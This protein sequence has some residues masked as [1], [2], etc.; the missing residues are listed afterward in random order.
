MAYLCGYQGSQAVNGLTGITAVLQSRSVTLPAGGDLS[1]TVALEV[2]VGKE[3]PLLMRYG[4]G[5]FRQSGKSDQQL[6][7]FYELVNGPELPGDREL[8]LLGK[9]GA[10]GDF[11][12]YTALFD[13]KLGQWQ[14]LY[15]GNLYATSSN[16]AWKG[17]EAI[18]PAFLAQVSVLEAPVLGTSSGPCNV[19]ACALQSAGL[20]ADVDF[21]ASGSFSEVALVGTASPRAGVGNAFSLSAKSE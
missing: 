6:S 2:S 16:D 10:A 21:S 4:F 14:F 13:S 8:R 15:D 19:E 7:I 17:Q 9:P 5:A 20:F 11:H 3:S 12:T 1:S 18:V